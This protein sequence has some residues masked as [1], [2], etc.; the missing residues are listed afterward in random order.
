MMRDLFEEALALPEADRL[1]L[2]DALYESCGGDPADWLDEDQVRAIERRSAEVE[3]GLVELIEAAA[4]FREARER[5][6]R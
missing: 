4:V 3:A 6:G 2:A 5:L 1:R